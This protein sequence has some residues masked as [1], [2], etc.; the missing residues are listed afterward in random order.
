MY[1]MSLPRDLASHRNLTH[2]YV[3]KNTDYSQQNDGQQ[4]GISVETKFYDVAIYESD[5][6]NLAGVVCTTPSLMITD[7]IT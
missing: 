5:V 1:G 4:I 2:Q 7:G 6:C 3:A